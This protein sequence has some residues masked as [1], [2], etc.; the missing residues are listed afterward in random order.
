MEIHGGGRTIFNRNASIG[1]LPEAAPSL[2]TDGYSMLLEARLGGGVIPPYI[3][4]LADLV[5]GTSPTITLDA[6]LYF[7]Y[8]KYMNKWQ[9][10]KRSTVSDDYTLSP[11]FLLVPTMGA[12]RIDIKVSSTT[13]S[14]TDVRLHARAINDDQA[15]QLVE[16]DGGGTGSIVLSDVPPVDV[17][18]TPASAGTSG[19]ASRQDHKHYVDLSQLQKDE[20]ECLSSDIVGGMVYV[21]AD[22]SLGRYV[23]GTADPTDFSKMP[24]VAMIISKASSTLCEIQFRGEVTGVYSGLTPGD[25]LYVGEDGNLATVP[26][27]P[28]ALVRK[29]YQVAGV[30]LASDVV[31]LS[32]DP[33]VVRRRL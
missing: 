23:V 17:T 25:V 8:A 21:R 4:I 6:F 18:G 13:G 2:P 14:P 29:Y 28:T 24:A 19:E 26:P 1:A 30:A 16:I 32:P 31:G 27:A 7:P 33:I 5:G 10:I 11:T 22:K 3:L 15:Y 9:L 20:A 12:R